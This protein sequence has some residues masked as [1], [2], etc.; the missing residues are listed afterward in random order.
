M[1]KTYTETGIKLE[2]IE[3]SKEKLIVQINYIEY[4]HLPDYSVDVDIDTTDSVSNTTIGWDS[5]Y[6]EHDFNLHVDK[7][8]YDVEYNEQTPIEICP[9]TQKALVDLLSDIDYNEEIGDV[10][11]TFELQHIYLGKQK[12]S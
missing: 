12:I 4:P 8:L 3:I 6:T 5:L 9:N 11:N 1:E 7:T 10:D 2:L